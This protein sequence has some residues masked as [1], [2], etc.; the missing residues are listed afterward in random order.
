MSENV[1]GYSGARFYC[2]KC[3][4]SSTGDYVQCAG[5]CPVEGTPFFDKAALRKYGPPT[6]RPIDAALSTEDVK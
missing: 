5:R 1:D 6:R 2:P 4:A 3:G